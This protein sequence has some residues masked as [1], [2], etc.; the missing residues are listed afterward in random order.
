MKKLLKQIGPTE[1]IAMLAMLYGPTGFIIFLT[2]TYKS[3]IRDGLSPLWVWL[4]SPLWI[5]PCIAISIIGTF[6]VI[7]TGGV[8]VSIWCEITGINALKKESRDASE[9][10]ARSL[11][12]SINLS[13]ENAQLKADLECLEEE[14]KQA[15][16]HANAR[17][18][19]AGIRLNPEP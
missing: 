11:M 14:R 15:E 19:R 2:P 1:V 9:R 8:L 6:V 3:I 17:L 12:E 18:L 4:A 13:H 5:I 10:A 16:L 7:A